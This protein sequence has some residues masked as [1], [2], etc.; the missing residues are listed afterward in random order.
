MTRRNRRPDLWDARLV[1][2]RG[3]LR[4]WDKDWGPR[5]GEPGCCVPKHLIDKYSW[6]PR[7]WDDAERSSAASTENSASPSVGAPAEHWREPRPG[8]AEPDSLAPLRLALRANG[9]RPVPVTAPRAG[10]PSF[11]KKPLLKAW[12]TVCRDPGE[13]A[14][15]DWS[16][17]NP[18]WSNTGLLCGETVGCDIDVLDPELA[19]EIQ[20]LARRMLGPTP[21]LR[22]GR[23][24]KCLLVYRAVAPFKKLRATL[25]KEGAPEA[26]IEILADGQHFVAF[27]KHPDTGRDYEWP[28]GNPMHILHDTL[29]VVTEAQAR[30]F[31][32]AAADVLVARAGYTAKSLPTPTERVAVN[33]NTPAPARKGVSKDPETETPEQL[34]ARAAF[35]LERVYCGKGSYQVWMEIG[36]AL[37]ALGDDLGFKVWRDWSATGDVF[38][39]SEIAQKWRHFGELTQFGIGT[40]FH[41]ADQA[42]PSWRE[43]WAAAR[44]DD[45]PRPDLLVHSGD[46]PATARELCRLFAQDGRFFERGGPVTVRRSADGSPVVVQLGVERTVLEAHRLCQP[47]AAGK[48]VTLP[49]RLARMYLAMEGDW[50]LPTLAGTS[51]LP[52]LAGDGTMRIAEGYDARTGLWCSNVAQ[53]QIPDR[54]SE[55]QAAEALRLLRSTFR[56]FPFADA[57]LEFDADIG[58]EVVSQTA[59]PG[60]DESTL[61]AGL[62]TAVCRP[63]LFLA[64]GLLVRAAPISGAGTGKGLLVRAICMIAFGLRPRSFPAGHDEHEMDKRLVAE[65]IEANPVL[66]LDNIN[67]ASLSSDTL[68]SVLTE[69]PARVRLLGKSRMLPVN[70][71]AFVAVTGNGITVSEDLARRFLICNLD[72][73]VEDPETRSFQPGF[74]EAIEAQRV[75]LLAAALT[76]WRWGRQASELERGLALGSFETWCGWVRDPLLALGC[77]DPVNR[78]AETKA[79]DPRRRHVA[80]LFQAWW[81]N[82][83]DRLMYLAE[84]SHPVLEIADP[85]EKGRQYL[86]ARIGRLVGTRAGGFALKRVRA[87]GKWGT[88]Q[89]Q[90]ECTGEPTTDARPTTDTGGN[91]P[92]RRFTPYAPYDPYAFNPF[93]VA[94]ATR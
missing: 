65:L 16:V 90:L 49:D 66:F 78:L 20:V 3:A 19:E 51:T 14:I 26:N 58:V 1:S 12:Q 35:A 63:S 85:H 71:T 61:L 48:P 80:D 55:Q 28:E 18:E 45:D 91:C 23:A 31:V 68:A 56:T 5:P 13:Q 69:R 29:P 82:H 73:G 52:L 11:G 79:N 34:A 53:V 27:G 6:P 74:L 25:T 38:K 4:Q 36:A 87:E 57:E 17:T 22:I 42:D 33:D 44:G 89:Y 50:S 8:R 40:V 76:I 46:L 21:L 39:T 84:L 60:L 67:R 32:R 77:M 93:R 64:P 15:I 2:Y 83:K 75:E 86:A 9:Y 30:D 81:D 37:H 7:A 92:Y 70:S 43:R 41:H 24:P 10:D 54:P 94:A 88:D 47:V 72:A 62:L 59:S